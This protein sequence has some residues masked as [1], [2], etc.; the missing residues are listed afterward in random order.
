[1][2]AMACSIWNLALGAG[3]DGFDERGLHTHTV[4]HRTTLTMSASTGMATSTLSTM[5]SS[6]RMSTY[7]MLRVQVSCN[8]PN[9][10]SPNSDNANVIL[11]GWVPCCHIIHDPSNVDSVDLT[12]ASGIDPL[13]MIC[14]LASHSKIDDECVMTGL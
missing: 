7:D 3:T 12:I 2:E 10:L 8:N 6:K 11:D 13:L 9:T 5:K 14:Y 1:M 4:V